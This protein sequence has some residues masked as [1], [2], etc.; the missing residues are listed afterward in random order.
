MMPAPPVATKLKSQNKLRNVADYIDNLKVSTFEIE[1]LT[2]NLTVQSQSAIE[3]QLL[4]LG[5]KEAFVRGNAQT[6]LRIRI[7]LDL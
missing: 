6:G 3:S 4:Q 7:E 2:G 1:P 5:C